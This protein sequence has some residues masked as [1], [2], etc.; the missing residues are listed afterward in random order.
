MIYTKEK[1]DQMLDSELAVVY[2]NHKN[3]DIKLFKMK[4]GNF[5]IYKFGNNVYENRSERNCKIE[6]I[7]LV[8]SNKSKSSGGDFGDIFNEIFGTKIWK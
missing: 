5:A 7:L 4:S 6:F 2:H 1:L 8:Q 3:S